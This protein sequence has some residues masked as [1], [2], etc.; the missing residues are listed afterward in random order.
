MSAVDH[1]R[2]PGLRGLP[3]RLP[4]LRPGKLTLEAK[5]GLPVL[6]GLGTPAGKILDGRPGVLVWVGV[7]RQ[8]AE[9]SR[10]LQGRPSQRHCW[11]P[12][13]IPGTTRLARD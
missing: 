2:Y 8:P 9:V 5:D 6:Q 10:R 13:L 11:R 7:V 3:Y 12:S 4:H 1:A